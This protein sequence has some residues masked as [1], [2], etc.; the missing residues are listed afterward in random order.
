MKSYYRGAWQSSDRRLESLNPYTDIP[1]EDLHLFELKHLDGA[2]DSLRKGA[3]A[4]NSLRREE[5]HQIF[6]RLHGILEAKKHEFAK[7][8]STEQGKVITEA[9]IEVD[10][11]ISSIEL[12]VDNP[13]MIGPRILPLS[14]E[15]SFGDRL[16]YTLRHP[17]G[18]VAIITAN[19]QPFVI[20]LVHSV[21]ALAAGNAV[22]LKPSIHTSVMVL[23][24]VEVLLETGF[25]AESVACFIGSGKTIGRELV[26]HPGINHVIA[27]GSLKTL[28][29]IRSRMGFI[30]SQLQWGCVA[31]CIVGKSANLDRVVDEL[32][33]VSFECSGQAAFTP[34]WVACF[35]QK[36][37]E[38]RER[39]QARLNEMV[40]GDPLQEETQI[41]P[42]TEKKKVERLERRLSEEIAKGA[43]IV[44]GG[45]ID[46]Q[47][48]Q[49]M[50][51]DRC[52]LKKTKFSSREIGAPIIGLTKIRKAAD[53]IT[54]LKSQR[55][56]VLT[57]FS[58]DQD[59]ASR[60]AVKMPFNNVHI[61]GI[62]NW[63]DG[64]ICIP[65]QPTRTG[66]R[67]SE[68][69]INDMSHIR[70]IIFH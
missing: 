40:C 67:T 55:Q 25:P 41:G 47:L 7:L 45:R 17:H 3:G 65:G 43:E 20:P 39:L 54:L 35:D 60:Q 62:P 11:A 58:K 34:T 66:R 4:L 70:D 31:T 59:W 64:L 50:L 5:L 13:F 53:A 46:K 44:A 2:I 9:R 57:L 28:Y 56:H 15:A 26:Q 30:T 23:K 10:S 27:A 22:A 49:P 69:R 6:T 19:P 48:Y 38:L 14:R 12:L 1:F 18:V 33:R 51:L 32:L 36:Y 24:L 21:F 61:N 29:D 63:R 8:I 52:D 16:G 42:L 68:D 37:D